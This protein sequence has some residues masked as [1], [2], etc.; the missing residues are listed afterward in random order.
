MFGAI[1]LRSN[2][3]A[4]HEPTKHPNTKSIRAMKPNIQPKPVQ[5]R[6]FH[7]GAFGGRLPLRAKYMWAMTLCVTALVLQA[8]AQSINYT[9]TGTGSGTVGGAA[10]FDAPFTIQ[11]FANTAD[12][13][14]VPPFQ[15]STLSVEDSSSTVAI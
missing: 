3:P 9:F 8:K 4:F 14:R 1:A 10:F 13:H 5:S 2:A 7:R 11:V 12:V 15:V 6:K